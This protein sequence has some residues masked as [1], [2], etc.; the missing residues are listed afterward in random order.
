MGQLHERYAVE[1]YK[2]YIGLVEIEDKDC[3]AFYFRQ[4]KSKLSFDKVLVR[5]NK[6]NEILPEMYKSHS[7]CV[8]CASSLFNNAGVEENLIRDRCGRLYVSLFKHEKASDEKINK[9][10]TVLGPSTSPS[11]S[12]VTNTKERKNQV[13]LIFTKI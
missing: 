10:S 3:N 8:T 5:V 13:V 9:M 4:S 7:L 11:V 6:L 12:E 1:V 2:L